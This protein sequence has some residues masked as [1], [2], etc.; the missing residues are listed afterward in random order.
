MFCGW[1]DAPVAAR[2]SVSCGGF[3]RC[4]RARFSLSVPDSPLAKSSVFRGVHLLGYLRSLAQR[5]GGYELRGAFGWVTAADV[6]N[7]AGVHGAGD[8][9]RS[10]FQ[11]G[12]LVREDVSV[13]DASTPVWIYRAADEAARAVAELNDEKHAVARPGHGQH[14]CRVY[15][16]PGQAVALDAMRH[17]FHNSTSRRPRVRGEP[18]WRT[19]RELSGWLR[20]EADRTGVERIFMS[21]DLAWVVRNCLAERRELPPPPNS[22]TSAPVVVYR[23]TVTG[24]AVHPLVWH[25]AKE[26]D[27]FA[28]A[29]AL[30]DDG[31]NHHPAMGSPVP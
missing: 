13:P 19:C 4:F 25:Q 6:A 22:F 27:A 31:R 26:P 8:E 17:A 3:C 15:L 10:A 14:G 7:A 23:L 16:R 9:L 24:A 28:I 12:E 1:I 5:G 21:D 20:D 29:A 18:E 11:R 30:R 2:L